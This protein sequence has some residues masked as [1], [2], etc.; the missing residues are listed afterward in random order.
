MTGLIICL[1][2]LLWVCFVS[3]VLGEGT[4][5]ANLCC[6]KET[7]FYTTKRN[8]FQC[9]LWR[10]FLFYSLKW[11]RKPNLMQYVVPD[12]CLPTVIHTL[13]LSSPPC[14]RLQMLPLFQQPISWGTH[15]SPKHKAKTKKSTFPLQPSQPYAQFFL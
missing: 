8:W 10:P 4:A 11:Y 5:Y 6:C 1:S 13:D 3:K 2:K 14:G 15:G 9:R 12:L 7:W